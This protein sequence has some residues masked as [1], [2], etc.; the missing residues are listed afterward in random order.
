MTKLMY[1]SY[2][3]RISSVH[4]AGDIEPMLSLATIALIMY[5]DSSTLIISKGDS[6]A[7]RATL[8]T[9]TYRKQI[10]INNVVNTSKMYCYYC[11]VAL[12]FLFGVTEYLIMLATGL[13]KEA[14]V[15]I[16][17]RDREFKK[18]QKEDVRPVGH[19]CYGCF[20]NKK[21]NKAETTNGQILRVYKEKK[22]KQ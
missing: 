2:S 1:E 11:I 19:T 13:I 16:Y 12:W 6:L 21:G 15:H 14:F 18:V 9:S 17:A 8:D 3:M 5:R 10:Y 22:Y 20:P 7:L 4:L